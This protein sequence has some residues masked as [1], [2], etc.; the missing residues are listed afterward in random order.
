MYQLLYL[1]EW[2]NVGKNRA[3]RDEHGIEVGLVDFEHDDVFDT[4]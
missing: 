3:K 2:K 4:I 1:L